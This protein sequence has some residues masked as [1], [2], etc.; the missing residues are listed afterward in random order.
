MS[1]IHALSGAY[2]V[3]ALDDHERGQFEA[4]L[5]ECA[6]CRAEVASFRETAALLVAT[7][8]ERPPASL[9]DGVL[10]AIGQ[11]RPLPPETPEVTPAPAPAP[12][13]PPTSGVRRR[14]APL[15]AAAAAVVLLAAGAVAWHPWRHEQA[16]LADRILHAP[17]AVR[18]TE[19]LP[20]GSGRLILVR[21]ATIGRAVMLADH[22]PDAPAGHTY[23][24]WL[25]QPGSQMASAGLMPDPSRPTV[26]SGDAA[27]AT[28][29]A[30]SVEPAGGSV[31]PSQDVVA[32]FPLK[33]PSSG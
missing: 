26:L 9:R 28:A 25:Q 32:V 15:L 16:S 29:A 22:V 11:V 10:H 2:T 24:L 23:Q 14:L 20:G 12:A 3:D 33:A 8:A 13:P 18:T 31:H 6:E 4:H 7:E 19:A 27:T 30:V 1:D 5:A 21:S 17:D